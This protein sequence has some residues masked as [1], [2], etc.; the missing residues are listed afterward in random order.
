MPRCYLKTS[1]SRV[2]RVVAVVAVAKCWSDERR[3]PSWVGLESGSGSV[4]P[5]T[6]VSKET[7]GRTREG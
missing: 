1:C 6:R 2:A 7:M 4:V 3:L 5:H